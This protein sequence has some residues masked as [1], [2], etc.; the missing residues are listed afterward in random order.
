MS[1]AITFLIIWL[2]LI[3]VG[4]IGSLIWHS[5]KAFGMI[6]SLWLHNDLVYILII[7][8]ALAGIVILFL[9]SKSSSKNKEDSASKNEEANKKSDN[10][11][12]S[13]ENTVKKEEANSSAQ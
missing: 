3:L 10:N 8:W 12:K 13:N 5:D 9:Y 11:T 6:V 4:S 7:G 1:A 2:I